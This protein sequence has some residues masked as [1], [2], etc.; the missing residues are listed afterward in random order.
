MQDTLR[1]FI[2]IGD[3]VLIRPKIVVGKTCSGLILPPGIEEKEEVQSGLVIKIGPGIPLGPFDDD[4]EVWKLNEQETKYIPLQ[5][6]ESDTAVY[7]QSKGWEVEFYRKKYVIVPQMA[8]LM[9]VRN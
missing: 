3:R 9:A 8:I 1:K 5:V 4:G 2:L 7:L 6:K